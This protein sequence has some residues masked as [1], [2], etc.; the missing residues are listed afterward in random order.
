[1]VRVVDCHTRVLGSNPGGPKD[2]PSGQDNLIK[3]PIGSEEKW[4]T[5]CNGNSIESTVKFTKRVST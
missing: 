4:Q 3:V 5:I 2:F 1:M